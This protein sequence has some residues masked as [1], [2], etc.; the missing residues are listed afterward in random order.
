MH[1][2]KNPQAKYPVEKVHQVIYNMIVTK[3][4]DRNL[5]KYINPGGDTLTYISWVIRAY[6]Q[7]LLGYTPDQAVLGR[8]MPI[9]IRSIIDWNFITNNK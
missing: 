4:L 6:Y 3:Y 5:Y 2:N 9:N 8:Y 7:C 1:T